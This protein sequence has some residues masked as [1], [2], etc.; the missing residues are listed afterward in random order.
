MPT[1]KKPKKKD[2]AYRE[3]LLDNV[4]ITDQEVAQSIKRGLNSDNAAERS[5]ALDIAE[6]WKFDE[7][8]KTDDKLETL[9]LANVKLEDLKH[10]TN[11]CYY[12]KHKHF[13]PIHSGKA[14][15]P[16]DL[17][18]GKIGTVVIGNSDIAHVPIDNLLEIP[19]DTVKP[20]EQN[21]QEKAD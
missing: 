4:G 10:L 17:P 21:P 3:K 2:R 16:T 7:I 19:E 20:N 13:E 8:K 12:C 14:I 15:K 18:D 11:R 1:K 6:R 9:P 5:K